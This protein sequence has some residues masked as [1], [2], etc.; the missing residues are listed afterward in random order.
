MCSLQELLGLPFC[1]RKFRKA[2]PS[3]I[4]P[5]MRN[6]LL[7]MGSL[8]SR[9]KVFIFLVIVV[10]I[11]REID[12]R[13]SHCMERYRGPLCQLNARKN[14]STLT[15]KSNSNSEKPTSVTFEVC[16]LQSVVGK[17]M[18]WLNSSLNWYDSGCNFRNP[19]R[20]PCFPH[21]EHDDQPLGQGDM[22]SSFQSWVMLKN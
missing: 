4:N 20:T 11:R 21:V 10:I 19:R 22:D 17:Q 7:E 16:Y 1:Q 18:W 2:I 8:A 13:H 5:C 6:H 3:N 14:W 12:A 15:C 9:S